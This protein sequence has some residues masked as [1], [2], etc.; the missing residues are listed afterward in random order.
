MAES[1][2]GR[3]EFVQDCRID[4]GVVVCAESVTERAEGEFLHLGPA[5]DG[6]QPFVV[7]D[8]LHLS[9]ENAPGFL[10]ETLVVPLRI[11][12]R[13][14][15]GESVVLAH[16]NGVRDGQ[17]GIFV[18]SGVACFEALDLGRWVDAGHQFGQGAIVFGLVIGRKQ[19]QLVMAFTR[20]HFES[21][22]LECPQSGRFFAVRAVNVRVV[23]KVGELIH[24]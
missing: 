17:I 7:R 22:V 23:Q 1:E 24:L 21:S 8:V 9:D 3:G 5:D 6:G 4:I 16:E 15:S 2:S 12:V 20:R 14:F 10:E 18:R 11:E 19:I 13:Q